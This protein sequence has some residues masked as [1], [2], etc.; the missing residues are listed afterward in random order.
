MRVCT[1]WTGGPV[2]SVWSMHHA[3]VGAHDPLS[4]IRMLPLGSSRAVCW[5]HGPTS[6]AAKSKSESRPP[7]FQTTS[8]R[9]TPVTGG[10]GD[11]EDRAEVPE[12]DQQVAVGHD[13]ERVDVRVV[14]DV[15]H[16]VG[17][18]GALLHSK[19]TVPSGSTR[20]MIESTGVPGGAGVARLVGHEPRRAVRQHDR[21]VPVGVAEPDGA[22]GARRCGTRR[23]AAPA[24]APCGSEP[25]SPRNTE[26]CPFGCRFRSRLNG[27][28]PA[29]TGTP[30]TSTAVS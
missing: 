30:F 17:A 20:W 23:R 15:A 9:P 10:G 19:P 3:W 12:R 2:G 26:S 18:Y 7:S 8:P 25:V 27:V 21:V 28:R 13:L 16:G 14:G 24:S 11:L 6:P 5:A 1:R 22:S 4:N 29:Y